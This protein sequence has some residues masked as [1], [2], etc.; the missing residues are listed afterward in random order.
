MIKFKGTNFTPEPN[1]WIPVNHGQEHNH[2]VVLPLPT[3]YRTE[4]KTIWG[5]DGPA[6]ASTHIVHSADDKKLTIRIGSYAFL[7]GMT[8]DHRSLDTAI[9]E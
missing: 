8:D 4:L 1:S 2:M 3:T 6:N 9:V 7:K 5:W